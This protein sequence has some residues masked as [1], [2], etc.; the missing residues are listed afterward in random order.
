MIDSV[1]AAVD[2]S[3]VLDSIQRETTMNL[4][5]II[6]WELKAG[7]HGFPGPD[8]GTCINEAAIVAMGFEYKAVGSAQ[9][10][11][12]C[13]SRPIASF[14]ISINDAMPNDLRNELLM[15]F[16]TRLGGTADSLEIENKR[17]EYM[18]IQIARRMIA[19]NLSAFG[20]T[21]QADLFAKAETLD[22]VRQAARSL[23]LA[24]VGEQ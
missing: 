6:N 7:S 8:G 12:P 24:R 21:K 4:D 15:P 11:P 23:D 18:I 5:H 14:A 2:R 17:L 19:L 13:F 22:D 9:D 20:Y 1:D 3:I 10:C 16:V